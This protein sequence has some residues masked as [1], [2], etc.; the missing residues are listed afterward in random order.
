MIQAAGAPS[1]GVSARPNALVVLVWTNAPTPAATASSSRTSVPVTLVSTNSCRAWDI[2]CGL[3]SVAVCS[4][5]V[6]AGHRR[7]DRGAVGDRRRD[8]GVRRVEEVEADDVVARLAQ[9]ADQRLT[10]VPGTAGHEDP[11]DAL[12]PRGVPDPP[13]QR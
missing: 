6:G 4:D 7:P 8:I 3:C 11:H 5:G 9:G 13:C 10:Q 2:T 1:P 12:T